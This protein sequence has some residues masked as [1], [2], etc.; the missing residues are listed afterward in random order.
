[1]NNYAA[2]TPIT[3]FIRT[4]I[5][6]FLKR[7]KQNNG[8]KSEPPQLR[9]LY[10]TLRTNRQL[11]NISAVKMLNQNLLTVNVG[12]FMFVV[13]LTTNSFSVYRYFPDASLWIDFLRRQNYIFKECDFTGELKKIYVQSRASDDNKLFI[14]NNKQYYK[15]MQSIII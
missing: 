4:R 7:R 14:K 5:T 2:A 1:M 3:E 12:G 13:Y 8:Y 9:H 10:E 11:K 15:L 6:D